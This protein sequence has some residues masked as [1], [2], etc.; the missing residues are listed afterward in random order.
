MTAKKQDSTTGQAAGGVTRRIKDYCTQAMANLKT[1]RYGHQQHL[2]D[3]P[4]CSL[5]LAFR[6]QTQGGVF[7]RERGPGAGREGCEG[8]CSLPPRAL[9]SPSEE[10]A[11]R[12]GEDSA[13][14][15][16]SVREDGVPRQGAR[17]ALVGEEVALHS[18]RPLHASLCPWI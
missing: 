13:R 12:Q 11:T 17:A 10:E 2:L 6:F 15:G 18:G 8:R 3:S 4:T 9:R 5:T 7:L 16:G 1:G 14:G